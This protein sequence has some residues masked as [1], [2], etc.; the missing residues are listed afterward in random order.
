ML[1]DPCAGSVVLLGF[2]FC[3]SPGRLVVL[4][5]GG[6]EPGKQPAE[7][8]TVPVVLVDQGRRVRVRDDVFLEPQVVA[9]DVVDKR[10][11]QNDI[12]TG[13]DRNVFVRHRR[14]AGEARVDVDHPR[15]TGPSLLH[16]LE[17]HWVALGHIR[18][19]DDDAIRVGH[20]L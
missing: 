8:L 6:V 18:A 16:P 13:P 19:L 7:I 17:T 20:V 3:V 5:R 2:L 10:T 15:P 12:R 9:Q 4:T 1:C 11:E 14:G